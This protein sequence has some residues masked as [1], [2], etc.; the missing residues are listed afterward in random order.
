MASANKRDKGI[1]PPRPCLES[2]CAAPQ[3][4]I[5]PATVLAATG[6]RNGMALVMPRSAYHCLLAKPAAAPQAS[7]PPIA[8]PGEWMTQK[9]SPPMEFIWG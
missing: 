8:L 4:E 5:V 2:L 6:P 1:L 7:M 9:E 3:P